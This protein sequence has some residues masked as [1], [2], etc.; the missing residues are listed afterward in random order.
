MADDK[1]ELQRRDDD[2]QQVASV[3]TG[4]AI[5]PGNLREA[6][7]LAKIISRSDLAPKD[8]KN[9]P[10]NCLVAIQFGAELGLQPMQSLQNIAVINGRP[11]IF[12]DAALG[13]VLA[14]GKAEYVKETPIGDILKNKV[15]VCTTKRR[16]SGVEHTAS[17]SIE[18]AQ[19]AKL[20]GKAGP[21]TEYPQR[22]MQMRARGFCLRDVYPDVLKGLTCAEELQ[23]TPEGEPRDIT[24]RTTTSMPRRR[25]APAELIDEDQTSKQSEPEVTPIDDEEK[26]M[27]AALDEAA[28]KQNEQNAAALKK[29]QELEAQERERAEIVEKERAE[30]EKKERADAKRQK[31]AEKT[32]EAPTEEQLGLGAGKRV[33]TNEIRWE[34]KML[35]TG[36]ISAV[37][38]MKVK[39]AA[40]KFDGSLDHKGAAIESIAIALDIPD[41]DVTGF[42]QLTEDEGRKMLGFFKDNTPTT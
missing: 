13:L 8:Y 21:W 41:G 3:L 38:F 18:D 24:P 12:G 36:G 14:S 6:Y 15:A 25:S 5:R 7:T 10:D 1:T 32:P 31:E 20:W 22:M 17:F 2:A 42:E 26:Q 16:G 11:G 27:Q 4:H 19:R 23:D 29:R 39:A 33:L 34:G 30:R 37:T 35:K 28:R 9:K 40:A